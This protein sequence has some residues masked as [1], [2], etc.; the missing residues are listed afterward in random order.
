M[1]EKK[2]LKSDNIRIRYVYK[3]INEYKNFYFSDVYIIYVD[4]VLVGERHVDLSKGRD[5]FFVIGK[6]EYPQELYE[7]YYNINKKDKKVLPDEGCVIL[8]S[9][10]GL[11]EFIDSIDSYIKN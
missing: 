9:E 11:L 6:K 1:E 4:D 5:L 8:K 10:E 7:E 2:E 3:G